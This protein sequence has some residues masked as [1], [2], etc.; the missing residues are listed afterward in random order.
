MH[1][2]TPLTI[3]PLLNP[4][5]PPKHSGF[6]SGISRRQAGRTLPFIISCGV[7]VYLLIFW[8]ESDF[9]TYLSQSVALW[10]R[11]YAHDLHTTAASE[12]KSSNATASPSVNNTSPGSPDD[13]VAPL[14]SG[15][16]GRKPLTTLGFRADES[17]KLGSTAPLAYRY[18]LSSFIRAS[19]PPDL[20]HRLQA[21]LDLHFPPGEN[22][23]PGPVAERLPAMTSFKN[24]WQTNKVHGGDMGGWKWRNPD[25]EWFMLNDVDAAMWVQDKLRGSRI[26][27]VWDELPTIILVCRVQD[28]V[29][30]S[31][32]PSNIALFRKRTS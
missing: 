23:D 13:D 26:E 20:H 21:R 10:N 14:Q 12:M 32:S 1:G 7:F 2:P 31:S 3:L 24:V 18:E 27:K 8:H 6:L 16:T 15:S 22:G 25:W 29:R 4:P 30:V 11:K 19:F 28:V 17:Y 5:L 9:R